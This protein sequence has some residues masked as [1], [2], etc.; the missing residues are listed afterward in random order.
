MEWIQWKEHEVSIMSYQDNN[1]GKK[2][3]KNTFSSTDDQQYG[4]VEGL[5]KKTEESNGGKK[6][7]KDKWNISGNNSEPSEEQQ[8]RVINQN[9]RF[10]QYD[11]QKNKKDKKN[12]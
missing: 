11:E 3:K 2:Q 12:R 5:D 1:D 8:T 6:E 7:K 10:N 9:I 4:S